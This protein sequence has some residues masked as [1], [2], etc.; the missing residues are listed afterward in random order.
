ML[1]QLVSP[2]VSGSTLAA[3][4]APVGGVSMQL[5]SLCQVSASGRLWVPVSKTMI[6]G[7]PGGWG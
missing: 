5:T 7:T 3:R 1:D 4:M 2:P 6:S